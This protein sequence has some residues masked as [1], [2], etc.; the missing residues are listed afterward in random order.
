MASCHT[1]VMEEGGFTIVPGRSLRRGSSRPSKQLLAGQ[2]QRGLEPRPALRLALPRTIGSASTTDLSALSARVDAA[3]AELRGSALMSRLRHA[4][5]SSIQPSCDRPVPRAI[6]CLGLGSFATAAAPRYQMALALLLREE[7]LVSDLAPLHTA[8]AAPSH[9]FAAGGSADEGGAPSQPESD[10][11]A[12]SG[13]E[14]PA[15]T[16]SASGLESRF[17]AYDPVFDALER[18]FLHS[19]GCA[20]LPR[21]DE[22][23]ITALASHGCTLF[24]MPHCGRQ[25]YSNLLESNWGAEPLARLLL[26]GNSLTSYAGLP[27]T[28]RA[29]AW[30]ALFRALPLVR[31]T[32]IGPAAAGGRRGVAP[33]G[34]TSG[35]GATELFFANAFNNTSLHAFECAPDMSREWWERP[36]GPPPADDRLVSLDIVAAEV[37]EELADRK[38]G[39]A[40][41]KEAM[42][43]EE[44]EGGRDDDAG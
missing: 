25:L 6:V 8:Q 26:L 9:C 31:E 28:E 27:G 20:L 23:R 35:G 37:G 22:G 29:A 33:S 38:G 14:L 42:R 44:E 7:L 1:A 19:R 21:N 39:G 10:Q 4:L 32:R 40:G 15:A 11:D 30:S 13:R 16:E 43:R 2:H 5:E 24:F 18:A 34:E 12:S 36:F 3:V 41:S 17:C